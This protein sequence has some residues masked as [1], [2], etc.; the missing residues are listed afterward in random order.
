MDLY[1]KRTCD[2]SLRI[3]SITN[4]LNSLVTFSHVLPDSTAFLLDVTASSRAWGSLEDL[5]NIEMSAC[6][7]SPWYS[8]WCHHLERDT[9]INHSDRN[10]Q[11]AGQSAREQLSYITCI[12]SMLNI[13][14]LKINFA[15]KR[16]YKRLMALWRCPCICIRMI[17]SRPHL[18]DMDAVTAAS[19]SVL[20]AYSGN[21][22]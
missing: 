22:L 1:K 19:A 13:Q 6:Q 17:T 9:R 12:F 4:R 18:Q 3:C 14:I 20:S 7:T 21:R 2:F 11:H 15:P 16:L 5:F 10:L 8:A